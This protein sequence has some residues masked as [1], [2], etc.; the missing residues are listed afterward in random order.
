MP[1]EEKAGWGRPTH[2]HIVPSFASKLGTGKSCLTFDRSGLIDLVVVYTR[3]VVTREGVPEVDGDCDYEEEPPASPME[4][5][6]DDSME[7]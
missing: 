7:E 2:P 5:R 6:T 3:N 4:A 1:C